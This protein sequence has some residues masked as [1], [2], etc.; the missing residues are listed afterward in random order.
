MEKVLDGCKI[1]LA[2]MGG[3]LGWLFGGFDSLIYALIAF[4]ALDYVTGGFVGHP[5]KEGLQ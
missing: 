1:A 3:V 2:C 4:V 5:R